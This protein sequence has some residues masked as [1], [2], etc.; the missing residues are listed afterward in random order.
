MF[1]SLSRFQFVLVFIS[2]MLLRLI[3]GFHF[4]KEGSDK[5]Q[6]GTFTS[7]YFL[8]GAKGPFAE[9]FTGMIEDADNAQ[10]LCVKKDESGKY[11]LDHKRTVLLWEDFLNKAVD[12]YD[13]GSAEL[14]E[15]FA[16]QRDELAKA[17][18]EARE[19]MDANVDTTKLETERAE[20]ERKILRLRQQRP[21]GEKILQSH[22]EQLLDWLTLNEVE[23]L[24]H[25]N[26]S[27]RLNGFERDGVNRDQAAVFVESLRYQVDSIKSDRNAKLRQWTAETKAL[28]DSYESRIQALPIEEQLND[29]GDIKAH[30]HF[31]ETYSFYK[32]VDKIIPWFDTIIGVSLIIGLFTRVSSLAAAA[33]LLSVVMSQPPWIPGTDPKAI[34]YAIEFAACV[35]IF[36]TA[37]GRF[38]GLDFFL[39]PALYRNDDQ[40]GQELAETATSSA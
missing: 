26:S 6:S 25:F 9:L 35:V 2:L 13:L 17:I 30:R 32:V 16:T 33:F 31:D 18:V 21:E 14:Q 12:V 39:N 37:A 28:W 7:K 36:A 29:G 1:S 5:L 8:A 19:A 11:V 22:R 3:V 34:L 15:K 10:Q 24:G 40:D 27:D 4:F 20:L 23:L 38:G